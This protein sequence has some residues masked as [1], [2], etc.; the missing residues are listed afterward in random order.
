MKLKSETKNQKKTQVYKII[1]Y[2][3]VALKVTQYGY[4]THPQYIRCLSL[5]CG[6]NIQQAFGDFVHIYDC[7]LI[8]I[9]EFVI[10]LSDP[11]WFM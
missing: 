8:L 5:G 4:L 9:L 7:D 11:Y 10:P 6:Y 2:S 3:N 1:D